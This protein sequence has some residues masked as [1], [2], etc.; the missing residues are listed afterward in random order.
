M[1]RYVGIDNEKGGRQ[2]DRSFRG[3]DMEK[4]GVLS[5]GQNT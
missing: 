1:E 4:D 3:V 5:A 2:T